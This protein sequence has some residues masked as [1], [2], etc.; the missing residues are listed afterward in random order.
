MSCNKLKCASCVRPFLRLFKK[1]TRNLQA[2]AL[3]IEPYRGKHRRIEKINATRNKKDLLL[4]M[5]QIFTVMVEAEWIYS[6]IKHTHGTKDE[7]TNNTSRCAWIYL[8]F[9]LIF[10]FSPVYFNQRLYQH[11]SGSFMWAKRRKVIR[12]LCSQIEVWKSRLLILCPICVFCFFS[13]TDW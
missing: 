5:S 4:T 3:L 8:G 12:M 9:S 13:L 10:F 6:V 1:K 11:L 2:D 7:G